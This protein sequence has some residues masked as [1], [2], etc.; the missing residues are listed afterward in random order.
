[1]TVFEPVNRQKQCRYGQMLYNIYDQYVGRSL[2]LYGEYSEGEVAMFRQIVHPGQV[3]VEVGANIGAHTVFLAQHVG[4]S[5]KVLAFEPQRILFQVLC[6][7]MALNNIPNVYCFQQ[8]LGAATAIVKLPQINYQ[9][10]YNFGGV[11]L[12]YYADGEDVSVTTLDSYNLQRCDL[13]KVDVEGMEN[14]V[15][16]GAV[17]TIERLKPMLYVENDRKDQ[18]AALIRYIDSL[19]Y[20][21]YWD[22]PRLYNPQNFL[23]NPENVFLITGSVN[24]LCVHRS[25]RLVVQG[26]PAIEVPPTEA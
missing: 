16:R 17:A 23:N 25:A 12:R 22:K 18:S 8:A 14:Q 11:A 9:K 24:M 3:I 6:A 26:A 15:L 10:D 1:M 21:M 13:L 20:T 2:D 7:N 5:G 4:P 19:G